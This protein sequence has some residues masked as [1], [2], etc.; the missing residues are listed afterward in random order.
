MTKDDAG[1]GRWHVEPDP[2][3]AQHEAIDQE[4]R[5]AEAEAQRNMTDATY[6]HP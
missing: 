4:R 3:Q 1:Q 5:A 2:N 6:E